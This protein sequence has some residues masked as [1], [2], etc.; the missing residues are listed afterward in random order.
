MAILDG[1]YSPLDILRIHF[2][3]NVKNLQVRSTF[4]RKNRVSM[5]NMFIY[6]LKSENYESKATRHSVPGTCNSLYRKNSKYWDIYF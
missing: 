1:L 2:V 5:S 4:V 3:I 6:K